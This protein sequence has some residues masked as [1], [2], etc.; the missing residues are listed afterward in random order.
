MVCRKE[1]QKVK[2]SERTAVKSSGLKGGHYRCL[3]DR[4]L[5]AFIDIQIYVCA[6]VQY[7]C[8]LSH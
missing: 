8:T 4:F 2:A 1:K 6:Y 3:H 5:S 7:I